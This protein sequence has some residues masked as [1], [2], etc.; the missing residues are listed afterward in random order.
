MAEEDRFLLIESFIEQP[1]KYKWFK[2]GE[3][4]EDILNCSLI[5]NDEIIKR[6]NQ[7]KYKTEIKEDLFKYLDRRYD[8]DFSRCDVNGTFMLFLDFCLDFDFEKTKSIVYSQKDDY[9]SRVYNSLIES[10]EWKNKTKKE[11]DDLQEKHKKLE[12]DY[13]RLKTLEKDYE[14]LKTHLECMPGGT[15]YFEAKDHFE[16]LGINYSNQILQ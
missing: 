3:L 5:S 12:K 14:R 11:F 7:S 13:D 2:I 16:K 10:Y 4:I 15:L 9:I 1:Q 8:Q 6:I